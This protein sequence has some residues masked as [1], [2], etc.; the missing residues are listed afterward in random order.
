MQAIDQRAEES[1]KKSWRGEV[2]ARVGRE[3]WGGKESIEELKRVE[4]SKGEW[5]RVEESVGEGKGRKEGRREE[6]IT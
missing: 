3:G 4:E 6:G 5:R 1:I 2:R